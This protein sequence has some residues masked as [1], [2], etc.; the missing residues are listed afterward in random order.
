M[1]PSRFESL[2]YTDCR[3]GQGLLGA[4]GLQFQ[5]L[6][7]GVDQDVMR[8][9]QRHLLYEPPP[10]WMKERRP[11]GDYPPSFAYLGGDGTFLAASGVYL[12]REP[13]GSREGNHLTHGIATA[14]ADAFQLVRP[15][16]LFG[17]AFWRTAPASGTTCEPVP[18]DWRPGPYDVEAVRDAVRAMPDGEALLACLVTALRQTLQ[19]SAPR[20]LF[21]SRRIDVVMT[22]LVA[23]TLLLPQRTALEIGFK[24]FTTNPAYAHQRVLAVHP[25]WGDI[26]ASETYSGYVVFD[27]DRGGRPRIA[28]SRTDKRWARMFLH[29]DPYDV[30]DAV[31]V[32]AATGLG[33]ADAAQAV[34]N[35]CV[36]RRRP[37]DEHVG[38]IA[39]WLAS[40]DRDLL[41]AYAERAIDVIIDP[42][43]GWPPDVL[44]RLD[45]A[46]RA[47]RVPS[48]TAA[49][50]EAVVLAA[51]DSALRGTDVDSAVPADHNT[52]VALRDPARVRQALIAAIGDAPP[53]RIDALL[54]VSKRYAVEVS[55][56]DL[57]PN[58]APFV[59]YW[60]DNPRLGLNP[61]RWPCGRDL[62]DLLRAELD[63]RIAKAVASPDGGA[64]AD[65]LGREWWWQLLPS[66]PR[67]KSHLDLIMLTSAM[68]VPEVAEQRKLVDRFITAAQP[69]ASGPGSIGAVANALFR[70]RGPNVGDVATLCRVTDAADEIDPMIFDRFVQSAVMARNLSS[71]LLDALALIAKTFPR[72][73]NRDLADLVE[74]D[75]ELARIAAAVR[76][77]ATAED[78]GTALNGIDERIR[79]V[80]RP[81]IA[82]VL[83]AETSLDS[84][85]LALNTNPF[86]TRDYCLR[87]V[88]ELRN[89]TARP[90]QAAVAFYLSTTTTAGAAVDNELRSIEGGSTLRLKNRL[91]DA[92]FGWTTQAGKTELA[93]AGLRVGE[94]GDDWRKEWRKMLVDGARGRVGRIV[95]RVRGGPTGKSS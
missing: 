46:L 48:R 55:S 11:P 38:S 27:F 67:A 85:R 76:S 1:T 66:T 16:Q 53:D 68:D 19:P 42:P 50:R 17:A 22:W 37:S 12:G 51:I 9:V 83:L 21:V 65:Q 52:S 82:Q 79:A 40:G 49:V 29:R 13:N 90:D 35:T 73:R 89:R 45:L 74:Q 24:M 63:D 18:A 56:A 33:Q 86:L 64:V 10:R 93:Q 61:G 34:A 43:T 30:L 87:L 91:H 6:S 84:V 2:I 25:D 59:R 41:D 54:A 28:A 77:G 4:A 5:A 88:D 75:R 62:R 39:R 81:H 31:E 94:L 72:Y 3:P 23:G 7:S 57:G 70:R 26:P 92:V 58:T 80:R 14:D 95:R 47:G 78:L 44:P 15:A 69:R 20:V 32:A 60:A 8:L 36:F 71:S